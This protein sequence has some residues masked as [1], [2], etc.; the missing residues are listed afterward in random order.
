MK[1]SLKLKEGS[2]NDQKSVVKLN[3]NNSNSSNNN[4][5]NNRFNNIPTNPCT[6][7]LPMIPL[8]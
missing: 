4:N 6:R 2:M 5:Y 1:R 8:P 3:F 7:L